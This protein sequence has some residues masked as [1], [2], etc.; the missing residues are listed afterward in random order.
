MFNIV[1]E[2]AICVILGIGIIVVLILCNRAYQRNSNSDERKKI[3][4]LSTSMNEDFLVQNALVAYYEQQRNELIERQKMTLDDSKF[5]AIV[6]KNNYS[7]DT[8]ISS[9]T[10]TP[11]SLYEYSG[12]VSLDNL[13][14][15]N[16]LFSTDAY[17]DNEQLS[18]TIPL[19][20]P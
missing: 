18:L 17:C 1:I 13:E 16:P 9:Q 15:S 7:R 11:Q 19:I 10:H 3:E 20:T 14:I 6:L 2:I 5:D 4:F 8:A 12:F